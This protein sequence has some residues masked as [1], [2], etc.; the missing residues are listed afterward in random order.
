MERSKY[1]TSCNET[2]DN[3]NID[4]RY[5]FV[6]APNITERKIYEEN[7]V[8]SI[9]NNKSKSGS[10]Y[11][12]GKDVYYGLMTKEN[13]GWSDF[14]EINLNLTRKNAF[15]VFRKTENMAYFS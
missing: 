13:Y 9:L 1:V 2:F 8:L 7:G 14:C 4:E 6:T 15:E 10:Y 3:I 11:E 12:D 5:R